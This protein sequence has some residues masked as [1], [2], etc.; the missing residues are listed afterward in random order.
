MKMPRVWWL[1]GGLALAWLGWR[2]S[3]R[4]RQMPCPAWLAWILE[5]PLT[6]AVAGANV[7]LDRIGLRPGERGLDVGCG[8]GR[9]ALPAAQRVG[10]AGEIV[11][12]DVQPAM[13]ARLRARLAEAAVRNVVPR[14]A[15]IA[16]PDALAGEQFDRAWLVTVLGEIPGRR[17]ALRNVYRLLRPGG[18]LSITEIFPDPHYQGRATVLRLGQE[19]GFIATHRWGTAL[20]FTQNFVRPQM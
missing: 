16:A 8:P 12:L 20:A 18:V 2:W 11:A 6:E 1:A 7:T 10:P 5:N 9:M 14:Q 3:S 19:A 15:D 4:R 17:A 13:L